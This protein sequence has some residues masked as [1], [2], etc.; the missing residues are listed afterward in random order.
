MD[1]VMVIGSP[2]SGKTTFSVKL[3][4]ILKLPLIHLD[5]LFWLE[6]WTERSK[7]EFDTLLD[8]AL[9]GE[10]WIIDGNYSRTLRKRLERADTVV[11]FDL[12][13]RICLFR[14]I[15][16]VITNRGKTRAD[17]G[18]GCPE[19]F[20]L[21]FLKYVRNFKKTNRDKILNVLSEFSDKQ[22]IIIKKRSDLKKLYDTLRSDGTR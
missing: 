9:Q 7:D 20:D 15:K 1:R 18:D 19:R 11:Y 5:K 21:E 2:G 12:P 14:V 3:A 8:E 16:R 22:I 4:E 6:G 17:M 10:R 13:T